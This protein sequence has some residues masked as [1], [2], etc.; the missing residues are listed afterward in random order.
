M[1]E[2]FTGDES[3]HRCAGDNLVELMSFGDGH[4]RDKV[5]VKIFQ[6][7]LLELNL[8]LNL[9]LFNC[10]NGPDVFEIVHALSLSII[11]D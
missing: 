6:V 2:R 7:I 10:L 11:T 1:D 4:L 8:Q 5:C 3:P 9:K